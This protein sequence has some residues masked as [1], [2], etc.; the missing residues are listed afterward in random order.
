MSTSIKPKPSK[1][2]VW[3]DGELPSPERVTVNLS[4]LTVMAVSVL[5]A[6]TGDTKTDAINKA[7]QFYSMIKELIS[8]GGAVYI[9]EPGQKELERI[10]IF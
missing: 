1:T 5:M 3:P 6:L 9:R 2:Q 10:A 8:K 7:L 4:A